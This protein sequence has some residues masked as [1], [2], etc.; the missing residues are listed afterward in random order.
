MDTPTPEIYDDTRIAEFA[1]AAGEPI[2]INLVTESGEYCGT[3]TLTVD[4]AVALLR[5]ADVP[6]PPD[7][8]GSHE[9]LVAIATAARDVLTA[10][11][12]G[13]GK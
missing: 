13:A 3:L 8:D 1:G 12:R 7:D 5:A 2:A 6:V 4:D 10:Y 11:V 9:L